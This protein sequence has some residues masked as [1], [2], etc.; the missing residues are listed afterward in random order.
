V[1]VSEK[2]ARSKVA[3]AIKALREKR[4]LTQ[5]QFAEALGVTLSAISKYETSNKPSRAMLKLLQ[6]MSEDHDLPELVP[7]F[8]QAAARPMSEHSH[9]FTGKARVEAA[10]KYVLDATLILDTLRHSIMHSQGHQPLSREAAQGLVDLRVKTDALHRLA[11]ELAKQNSEGQA[12]SKSSKK[13][14]GEAVRPAKT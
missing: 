5:Q 1:V 6:N 9:T 10:K 11:E 7:I 2:G 8:S 3:S 14:V 12:G 4:G 13:S